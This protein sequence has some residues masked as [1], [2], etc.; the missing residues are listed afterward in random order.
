[1]GIHG[2]DRDAR[3]KILVEKHV[4]IAGAAPSAPPIAQQLAMAG[5]G[6]GHAGGPGNLGW[7]YV[8]RHPLG[9]KFVGHLKATSLAGLTGRSPHPD[10]GVVG[11]I[12]D[13][14]NERNRVLA[15]LDCCRNRGLAVGVD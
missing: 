11:K 5:V 7:F 9:S 4:V 10:L 6:T 3:Q 13:F 12:E 1:M 8:G 2:R 14:R 15:D